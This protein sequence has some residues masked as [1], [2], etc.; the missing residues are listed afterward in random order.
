MDLSK[1]SD[2]HL[3]GICIL[4]AC[5]ITAGLFIPY[6]NIL[7][8]LVVLWGI[9]KGSNEDI[10]CLLCFILS[11]SPIFK[12][13]MGGFTLFNI[14]LLFAVAYGFIKNRFKFPY[15]IG[16]LILIF[17]VYELI[18]SFATSILD[19]AMVILPFI[20]IALLYKPKQYQYDLRKI[21]T[22]TIWGIIYTSVIAL[23]NDVIPS[24]GYLTEQTTI[25]LAPGEYYY[26][27]SGL[28][29]NPNYYT[30]M[31]S[32]VLAIICILIIQGEA[33]IWEYIYFVVLSVFGFMSVSQSFMIT[34]T[35]MILLLMIFYAKTNPRYL[36]RMLVITLIM[37]FLIYKSLDASTIETI[38][39]RS[40]SVN[41]FDADMSGITSGRTELWKNYLEYISNDVRTLIFGS[42]IGA[43]G[44]SYGASHSYYI[45]MIY[46]LGVIG[47]VIYVLLLKELFG[48][49]MYRKKRVKIYQYLPWMIFLI[50]AFARNLILSEQLVFMMLLC[51]IA[52]LNSK[53]EAQS[54]DSIKEK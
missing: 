8:L 26:R 48:I 7:A 2:K 24:I 44:L 10:L 51:S 40:E 47:T 42:G 50:R 53:N 28:M 20:M 25:R 6:L 3:L 30:I 21:N 52:V 18:M 33:K 23:F 49:P 4:V 37:G 36:I 31:L 54:L 12:I 19:Y 41:E 27:Y 35:V 34:F 22:F 16:I 46:H 32:I 29:E 38:L 43:V 14:V 39:F 17:G 45:D 5:T 13:K 15:R 1:K 9:F 11:F